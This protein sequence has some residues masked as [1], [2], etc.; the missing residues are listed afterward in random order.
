MRGRFLDQPISDSEA[1]LYV[2]DRLHN[3]HALTVSLPLFLFGSR[4]LPFD[5]PATCR[6]LRPRSGGRQAATR[7]RDSIPIFMDD[8][9]DDV[10]A[11]TTTASYAAAVL[12]RSRFHV[13][14]FGIFHPDSRLV[15]R[16]RRFASA[17][18]VDEHLTLRTL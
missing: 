4:A 10:H 16:N 2:D 13:R 5:L 9:L 15:G 3:V 6:G 12:M 14:W 1:R 8:R 17:H 11:R 18:D 7:K